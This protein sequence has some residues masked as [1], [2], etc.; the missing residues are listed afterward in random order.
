MWKHTR[1]VGDTIRAIAQPIAITI[2][3]TKTQRR[4]P[5]PAARDRSKSST[6]RLCSKKRNPNEP[7]RTEL[8]ESSAG[9]EQQQQ[10]QQQHGSNSTAAT[11]TREQHSSNSN[12]SSLS[13]ES[14]QKSNQN[15]FPNPKTQTDNADLGVSHTQKKIVVH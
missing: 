14:Y 15:A 11:A 4:D 12:I 1:K 10:Q 13:R 2:T 6:G 8:A 3:M 5:E 9:D 7:N